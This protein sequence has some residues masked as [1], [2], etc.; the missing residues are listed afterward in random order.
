VRLILLT[1]AAVAAMSVAVAAHAAAPS[2]LDLTEAGGAKFPDR[3]FVVGLPKVRTGLTPADITVTENGA[4]VTNVTVKPA[5]AA[6]KQAFGTVLLL[7]TSESMAG[8]PLDSA[9]AAARTFAA[10]RNPNQELAVVTFNGTT[11][12]VLPFTTSKAKIDAALAKPPAVAYGTH[13][14]DAVAKAESMLS[15]AK[16]Q[17][18]SIVVLSDGADSGSTAKPADVAK[19]ARTAHVRLFAIGLRDAK[20]NGTTLLT[21]SLGGGGEYASAAA[22]ADLSSLFDTLGARLSREYVVSYTSLAGPNLPVRVAVA[23]DGVGSAQAAY[24]T[25]ELAVSVPKPYSESLTSRIL[26]SWVAMLLV[27]ALAAAAVAALV[28]SLLQ[29]RQSGLPRR[30]AEFV[31]V[32]GLQRDDPREARAGRERLNWVDRLDLQLEIARIKTSASTLVTVTA[33]ATALAILLLA[34]VLGSPW[35]GLLGLLVPVIVREYVNRRL[36][37]VRNQFAEQLPDSLQII[38]AALRAGH[39]FAGALAVVV[40]RAQDPMRSEMQT[41]VA[42]EQRGIPLET[43]IAVVVERMQNTDLEQVALVAQLQRD[44]GGNAAEVVDRVAE[45]IRERFE[46]RRLVSTLTV[47]GRMSRWIVTGLPVALILLLTLLNPHYLHPLVS[48]LF[49][50]VLIGFGVVLVVGGSLVIKRIV[51]IEV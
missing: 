47:Q 42:D 48:N 45:T 41:V 32:P 21:L 9:F 38:G 27:A 2:G 6:T 26:G 43:A 49:G 10:Q 7:D 28:I 14:Y 16:I 50:K 15:D 46:L 23:V 51:E 5:Q 1:A 35:W 17:S 4:A 39:S 44:A 37:R 22:P 36:K 19:R 30:M 3:A 31:S 29:P 40:E 24:K 34:V 12:V 8:K 33:A 13:I 11:N 20:F 25:P 18:G